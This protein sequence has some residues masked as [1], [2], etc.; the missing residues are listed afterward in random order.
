MTTYRVYGGGTYIRQFTNRHTAEQ[1]CE[2]VVRES[3]P[4]VGEVEL[5][6]Q[7]EDEWTGAAECR[8]LRSFGIPAGSF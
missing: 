4:N 6:R 7:K 3:H 8:L 2:A 5:Y 1:Y